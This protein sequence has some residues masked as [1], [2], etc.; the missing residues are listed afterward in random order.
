MFQTLFKMIHFEK[1]GF[2]FWLINYRN[3]GRKNE[4]I[5]KNPTLM[6]THVLE[7]NQENLEMIKLL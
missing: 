6:L 4:C 2:L 1:N 3:V 5:R 7:K